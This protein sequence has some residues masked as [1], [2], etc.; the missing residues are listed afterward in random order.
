MARKQKPKSIPVKIAPKKKSSAKSKP[1]KNP[2]FANVPSKA[3]K[4]GKRMTSMETSMREYYTNPAMHRNTVTRN[5]M[6]ESQELLKLSQLQ[7]SRHWFDIPTMKKNLALFELFYTNLNHLMTFNTGFSIPWPQSHFTWMMPSRRMSGKTTIVMKLLETHLRTRRYDLE[8]EKLVVSK[9]QFFDEILLFSP[10]AQRQDATINKR[11]FTRLIATQQEAEAELAKYKNATPKEK[12]PSRL[13]VFDDCHSWFTHQA[14]SLM[15][16]FVTANRHYNC[17]LIFLEQQF[18]GVNPTIRN[19]L[20]EVTV[21]RVAL[22]TELKAIEMGFG[23][24]FM[25]FYDQVDWSKSYNFLHM[26]LRKGPKVVF[27]EG[28]MSSDDS[29]PQ[30]FLVKNNNITMRYL[31]SDDSVIVNANGTLAWNGK[32]DIIV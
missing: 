12:F 18:H 30:G 22:Q 31:G 10:T 17:S 26:T 16:W 5:M 24:R 1:Q 14:H 3:P 29:Q 32:T 23:T 21:F 7:L 27:Y 4:M 11:L 19:N 15:E 6:S 28:I 20:S 9:K 8:A 13:L 2:I 25:E